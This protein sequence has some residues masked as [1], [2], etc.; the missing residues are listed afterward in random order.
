MLS[1]SVETRIGLTPAL[2]RS[3]HAS[4]FL[5]CTPLSQSTAAITSVELSVSPSLMIS[6]AGSPPTNAALSAI[7]GAPIVAAAKL[8]MVEVR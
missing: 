7:S 1:I 8:L 4:S 3:A 2:S 5:R 6:K